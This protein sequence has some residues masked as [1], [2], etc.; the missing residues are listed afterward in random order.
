[1]SMVAR[2]YEVPVDV[3]A[4]NSYNYTLKATD[5][6]GNTAT[7]AVA[8][9]ITNS[10]SGDNSPPTGEVLITG[11]YQSGQTLKASSF[12]RYNSYLTGTATRIST[13]G[14][15]AD[16]DPINSTFV[17]EGGWVGV[18]SN[19]TRGAAAIVRNVDTSVAGQ[20]TFWVMAFDDNKTKAVQVRLAN[21]SG[22][23]VSAQALAAKDTTGDQRSTT[24]NFDTGG[25]FSTLATSDSAD[26]LGVR[27][28]NWSSLPALSDL[29]GVGTLQYQ[30]YADGVAISGATGRSYT[31]TSNEI[32]KTVNLRVSYTDSAGKSEVVET[33][34]QRVQWGTTSSIGSNLLL[35]NNG[36][37]L[38]TS[39]G[40]NTGSVLATSELGDV[41][42]YS[43]VDASAI[44]LNAGQTYYIEVHH[45]EGSGGDH[46][47]VGWK[48]P[49]PAPSPM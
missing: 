20:L 13:A 15:V 48:L 24:F 16:F 18:D 34:P 4:N 39:S 23:G 25:N 49:V 7:Q 38:Q 12:I 11:A 47:A 14:T 6:A 26:G 5:K 30:W 31:L 10:T 32:G 17:M 8:I 43:R 27:S 42:V 19:D 45:L 1:M 22:G 21:M 33:S 37:N 28:S 35:S 41:V 46:V 44:T 36:S 29:D 9:S 3:G 2:D 40:R